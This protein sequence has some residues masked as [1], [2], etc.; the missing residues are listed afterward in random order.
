MISI[1]I[2]SFNQAR[3]L[4]R[5]LRSV[6][7]QSVPAEVIVIDGGST[8]GSV[9]ILRR[10]AGRLAHWV[11]EPDNGQTHAINK[12]MARATGEIRSYLNSDDVLLP[13]AL[14]AVLAAH[15]ADPEADLLH[16][17]CITIDAEDR[18]LPRRFFGDFGTPAE[19]LDL[20]GVWFAGRNV[21]QPEVFWTRRLA[22]RIGPFDEARHYAMDYDYW[23]RA[24]LAGA[25]VHRIDRD[26]AAFR[27]WENQKSTAAQAAADELRD[28][29]VRHLRDPGVPLPPGV[30]RRLLG[31]WA[32]D[33]VFAKAGGRLA[34]SG[35]S[36]LRRRLAMLGVVLGNPELLF[37]PHFRRHAGKLVRRWRRSPMAGR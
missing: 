9:E 8:D 11:S 31:N 26:L 15:A 3:F 17:R 32:F 27:L 10:H 30:R 19:I 24:I 28:I 4:E 16:G 12:G 1:V 5:T 14:E 7:E 37:S 36:P 33:E 18:V 20:W 13:G 35:L 22:E 2:P 25:R 29:A 21:V 23:C 34:G 6:F